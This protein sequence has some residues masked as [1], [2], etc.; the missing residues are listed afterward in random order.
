MSPGT[1][2][3]PVARARAEAYDALALVFRSPA[4]C[5]HREITRVITALARVLVW[6]PQRLLEEQLGTLRRWLHAPVPPTPQAPGH[7]SA[8][9]ESEAFVCELE[10]MANLCSREAT[11]WEVNDGASAR[12]YL[13]RQMSHLQHLNRALAAEEKAREQ[14]HAVFL[15]IVREYVALDGH[16]VA[17]MLVATEYA[18]P[19]VR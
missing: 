12:S 13:L 19:G 10:C 7:G 11:A 15:G 17:A 6:H 14:F 5:G 16:L 3:R 8:M 2:A 4:S 1:A 9:S 18:A